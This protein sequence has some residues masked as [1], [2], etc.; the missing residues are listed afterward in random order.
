M[1]V[2]DKQS[3]VN[4]PDEFTPIPFWFWNDELKEEELLRQIC[5]FN[6][7]GV[8]GFVIHPRIG[9]PKSIGYLS[10]RFME[11]VSYAVRKAKELGMVVVLYDEAM[12]PSGS[13]HGLV[14]KSNPEYA[15]KGLKLTEF[16]CTGYYQLSL[17]KLEGR[18]VLV[19]A[20][21]KLSDNEIAAESITK[22]IIKDNTV[23][24]DTGGEEGWTVL[25][26][27]ECY[28]RGHIRGIHFGEDDG[29]EEAPS[30]ADLL[31][32]AATKEF[33]RL[34]HER[35][36][37]ALKEYFGT[38]ITGFFTDEPDIMGRGHEKGLIPWTGGFMEYIERAGFSETDIPLLWFEDGDRASIVRKKYKEAVNQKMEE[39]YYKPLYE[40]C[41]Q[42]GIALTGHPGASD[43]IGFLKYFHT[44]AQDVVWRWVAP[45]E[46]RAIR[47]EHSTM[48][49]CS[50]DSARHRGK[51]RNGNECFAC[52]GKNK[53]EW[54]FTA[55][56]MKWYMDWLFV[57]GVNLLYP[58]AFFYS[59]DGPRRWGERPPDVG[60]NNIW[61]PYYKQI[62]DYIKRM[63]WV[64][65]DSINQARVAVLCEAHRLP[66]EI[67][68]PL[69][70]NQLEFNYLE[71]EILITEDCSIE[72]SCLKVRNQSYE[73]LVLDTAELINDKNKEK[74]QYFV[75]QG[76]KVLIF[77]PEKK[78]L[79]HKDLLSVDSLKDL[80]VVIL[81]YIDPVMT[82]TENQKGLRA[83]HVVKENSDFFLL[84]NE[85]EEEIKTDLCLSL[86]GAV[87]SWDAVKGCITD[88]SVRYRAGEEYMVIPIR[89]SPREALLIRVDIRLAPK[90]IETADGHLLPVPEREIY[91]D[92][93]WKMGITAENMNDLENFTLWNKTGWGKNYSGT[94]VYCNRFFLEEAYQ[95]DSI[96]LDLG[97]VYEIATVTLNGKA[98][99]VKL[100]APFTF[101]VTGLVKEGE[102]ELMVEVNNTIANRLCNLSL[103]SGL[104]GPV[105]LTVKSKIN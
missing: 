3:F 4:P 2:F 29:E 6:E 96:Q 84:V 57:R 48:A 34:T 38:T 68:E 20:V 26:F 91:L 94:V 36:Y 24:F 39:A 66:S 11:L 64:M 63:C 27:T 22:L 13:A 59:I 28:T 37:D 79:F 58:H 88:L 16:K 104:M 103:D 80:A 89:L 51:R 82:F 102:N 23:S 86:V 32:P 60:P 5:D 52:C 71:D 1:A 83:T 87:E 92:K 17:E 56:D 10:D 61:W 81:Q 75:E 44:P 55:E 93:D 18:L 90:S 8:K 85:G 41:D 98:A 47:G 76:G 95:A 21:R 42:H 54:S 15:S 65:T 40:W 78:P 73:L 45:E 97:K 30:S 35:Y 100:W 50:S 12:Y 77:N 105:R 33:I 7:K 67:A 53:I 9:I 69:F 46:G 72:D 74:I 19:Q 70:E 14:V 31:N 25:V 49:K 101:D 62:S 43:D 99:G